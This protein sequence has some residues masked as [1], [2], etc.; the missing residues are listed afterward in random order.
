MA[1][2]DEYIKQIQ[3]AQYGEEVRGS[4]VN[5]LKKVNDDNNSYVAI[6]KE[7][8]AAKDIVEEKA[9]IFDEKA[10]AAKETL[11]AL[12]ASTQ[13][14]NEAKSSLNDIIS[15]AISTKKELEQ[16]VLE[17]GEVIARVDDAKS[18]LDKSIT[19]AGEA[20]LN[21]Q[22]QVDTS[23]QIK[24]QLDVSNNTAIELKK[25]LDVAINE[26]NIAKVKLV[27][28]INNA[29]NAALEKIETAQSVA[30]RAVE[31]AKTE[32][33]KAVQTEGTTQIGNVSAEGEKQV[34]AV[35][36]A[37][38]EIVADRE[39]I[40]E[41]KTG[42][43]KL[44]EDIGNKAP[45]IIKKASGKTIII[46]DSSNLPIKALSGTGEIIVTGKNILKTEKYNVF[47][48]FEAKAGTLFTL[49]TNGELSEGGNIRFTG[50]ND[51][52]IWFAID[53]G[54]TRVSG[55]ISSN[56]KGYTNLLAPKE[57]LKYC[58]SVG[59]NDRY[60][61][62]VEQVI[63]APVDSEQLKA[64]H[65]NYP[66]TVLTS[67]N[68]ISVE[69]VADTEAYIG[70]RIKEE[71]QSLQKQILDIQNALISQKISGG[72]IIQVKDS[73]KLPLIKL[74]VFGNSTQV[75]TTGKNLLDI[76]SGVLKGWNIEQ[77][78]N[79]FTAGETYTFSV[80]TLIGDTTKS[81]CG[82]F[83]EFEDGAEKRIVTYKNIN[84][85]ETFV[86]PDGKVAN[87]K[88]CGG[89]EGSVDKTCKIQIE[90]GEIATSYEPYTGGKPSPSSEYPQEITSCGD[91]G[92]IKIKV[93]G[94]NLIPFPYP[95]ISGNKGTKNGIT[96]EVLTDGGIRLQGTASTAFYLDLDNNLK[97]GDTLIAPGNTD[98]KIAVN[99]DVTYNGNIA[100]AYI[101][102]GKDMT[103]NRVY[104]PQIEYGTI[105]TSYEPYREPQE[106]TLPT[107]NGLLG[108]KVDANGNYTD[109][110]GQQWAT[111]EIDLARGK[112]V[113]RIKKRI[114]DGSEALADNI[115]SS[116]S[117][118]LKVNDTRNNT[119]MC[120]YGKRIPITGQKQEELTF[121]VDDN[122]IYLYTT[123]T[124][125][126]F[127]NL[128]KQKYDSGKPVEVLYALRTPI[129]T[130]LPQE[131][132]AAFKKLHANYPTTL[133][134]N[135]ADAGME[136]TYTVDTQS[137]VDSKIATLS[138]AL[139]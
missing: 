92:T 25:N 19:S 125:N 96:W 107:L 71:N 119:G 87:I 72:G 69:Y 34:Q 12:Q 27:E 114:F 17:T 42:I 56:V 22:Q 137:Y 40:Q 93:T 3:Q 30:T 130:D 79:N 58:F 62:Y 123:K 121:S 89:S 15:S 49:I 109:E 32:A 31:T 76:E 13:I 52:E 8:V 53:K 74:A 138:K 39:Q 73:A 98:G 124:V 102:V 135:N 59:E 81:S 14:A 2:I 37:A 106:L 128:L 33:I 20:E 117:Y 94:K 54:K 70:K 110:N 6:K 91:K 83:V 108:L 10:N 18:N 57:G 78:T 118:Y 65:T 132:I 60:E 90:K 85:S 104:Y 75:Q 101:A 48:P 47:I 66:T 134:S 112:Y 67:E 51:E 44:K 38:Q 41:N 133:V 129:E 36:G 139:L 46:E 116:T 23:N 127:K 105:S 26:A 97:I 80:T 95:T 9:E 120:N 5:A 131:T 45:A 82:L 122:G 4:I 111:D 16:V 64:I 50:E 35:Q 21:L 24:N 61:E 88:L 63:T 86:F 136:L 28:A 100:K 29:G 99:K 115:G 103:V 7:V 84:T 77:V 126:E 11:T 55:K 113:Q 1:N 43:A 68:E